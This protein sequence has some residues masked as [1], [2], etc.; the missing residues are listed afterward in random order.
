MTMNGF[1]YLF[2]ALAAAAAALAAVPAAA[3]VTSCG[4]TGQAQAPSTVT[5][6]PFSPNALQQIN[7]PLTLTRFANGGAKTQ[8]VSFVL[9]QPVGAPPYQI[10]YNG[11]N[12]LYPENN[13][14][15]RPVIGSQTTGQIFYS[16]GGASAPDQSTPFNLSVTI[17]ANT[18]LS[19][20][21]PIRFDILYVCNGT[22]GLADV[23]TPRRLASAIQINVNVLSALQ[24]SY[25]GPALD[26]GDLGTKTAEQVA[27]DPGPRTGFVRVASSGPYSVRMTSQNG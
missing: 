19:A 18:D 13:T 10:L 26:F 7:I 24:A 8:S 11:Q 20:G 4:V 6:D 16:F 15:G 21:E 12:V 9:I 25:V 1:K 27:S 23:T 22:G 14:R 3:Q 2:L 17:P 5:Y